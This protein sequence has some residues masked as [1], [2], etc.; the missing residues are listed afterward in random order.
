MMGPPSSRWTSQP[1]INGTRAMIEALRRLS[2]ERGYYEMWV[3]TGA[4]NAPAMA[5]YESCGGV[6]ET[7]D[8]VMWVFPLKQA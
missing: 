4:A 5:L 7:D 2:I 1:P 8:D 6:R 3:L